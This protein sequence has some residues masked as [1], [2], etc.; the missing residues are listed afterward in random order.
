M[1]G[2]NIQ[3]KPQS[4]PGHNQKGIL[5]WCLSSAEPLTQQFYDPEILNNIRRSTDHI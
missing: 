4:Y 5:K 1:Y 2:D 3:S